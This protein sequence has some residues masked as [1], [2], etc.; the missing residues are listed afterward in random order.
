MVSNPV[1]E[2]RIKHIDIRYHYVRE[3]IQQRQVE[4]FFIS[5]AENPADMFTKNLGR[6]KFTQF[7]S[8]LGLE[9]Y[10]LQDAQT[11]LTQCNE[12]GG[13]SR[14]D[15]ARVASHCAQRAAESVRGTGAS[16]SAGRCARG[17][18]KLV[19]GAAVWPQ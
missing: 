6:S 3:V 1:Q 2:R 19:R 11:T 18:D 9:I 7:R 12:R 13:V 16:H 10:S 8:T 15:T 17:N 5:G 4:L 14:L